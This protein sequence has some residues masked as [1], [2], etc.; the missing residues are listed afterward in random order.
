VADLSDR[1]GRRWTLAFGDPAHLRPPVER[2]RLALEQARDN[3]AEVDA[4]LTPS[5]RVRL[6]QI[7][8]QS[9]GPAGFR[10]PEV[11]EALRL[12]TGQRERILAIEEEIFYGQIRE[13]QSGKPPEDAGRP[14]I[15]RILAGLSS[16]QVRRW[17]ELTGEPIRGPLSVF[18]MP[19]RPQRDSRRAPR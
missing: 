10:E 12:T 7:A 19:F 8:L 4:I 15:E 16:E 6:R 14:A 5:Q 1:A 18:P 2:A 3:E 13:I 17:K 11:V 9:E